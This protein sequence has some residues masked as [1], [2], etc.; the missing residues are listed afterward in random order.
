MNRSIFKRIAATTVVVVLIAAAGATG[1]YF[2]MRSMPESSSVSMDSMSKRKVLYWYD[3]MRPEVHFDQPGKSPFMDMQLLPKY[4]DAGDGENIV[5]IDPAVV[6]N[7]GMRT[8]PAKVGR[9]SNILQVPGTVAWNQRLAVTV[10][11]RTNA[12]IKKLYVRAPFTRVK[13][14]QPLAEILAP[15]WSAAAAEYFALAHAQSATGRALRAAARQRLLA[16]GM[17]EATLRGLRAGHSTIT[18]RAPSSGVVSQ[19]DARQ[20]A[21][22]SAGMP[23]LRINGLDTVW[24]NAAIPQAQSSSI[25]PGAAI[26]ATVSALPGKTFHGQVKKLLPKV[27]ARSRTQPARIVLDNPDHALAP[28]MFVDL[29]IVG[30]P[31]APHPLVPVGAL[32]AD[33]IHTRVI[34][35]LGNGQ[36]R[37]VRVSTGRA[38]NGMTEILAGLHGGERIVTSGQFLIDSEASLSGVLQRMPADHKQTS[39]AGQSPA[40]SPATDTNNSMP[41]MPMN[42]PM[43]PVSSDRRDRP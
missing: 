16:L 9:L 28:G 24:V 29:R 26:T 17:D 19:I 21:Q 32:I 37:P 22:V 3:P 40:T 18:L 10:S 31:G 35:A 41:G 25:V 11:A 34:I 43:P 27:D 14:G 5:R 42:M 36:Y 4:A 2:A 8:Q 20:G 1:Y 39:N 13:A 6:Q 7:L 23:I 30:K 38:Y 33:G 15:Q 12:T